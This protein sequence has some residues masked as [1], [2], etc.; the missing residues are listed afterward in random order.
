[1]IIIVHE[2]TQRRSPSA[3]AQRFPFVYFYGA[4]PAKGERLRLRLPR[5]FMVACSTV[6][7]TAEAIKRHVPP[8]ARSS[9]RRNWNAPQPQC[10]FILIPFFGVALKSP[11]LVAI[12]KTHL[13]CATGE[14]R[15]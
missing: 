5:R 1:M 2:K 11:R 12:K 4:E 10:G 6:A 7:A 3:Q 13:A 9:I 15:L 8:P 14:E